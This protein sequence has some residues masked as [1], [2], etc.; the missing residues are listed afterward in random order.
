MLALVA[1]GEGAGSNRNY[2]T[3]AL[4]HAS[5]LEAAAHWLARGM[6]HFGIED[7]N[8]LQDLPRGHRARVAIA[9]A[10]WRK[11]GVSQRWIADAVDYRTA[12][13]VSQQVRRYDKQVLPI[14]PSEE[15]EWA[16]KVN[17]C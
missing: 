9:W 7:E 6:R 3:S 4:G 12:A 5:T 10:I 11:T 13:N 17:Y 2:A 14:V 15:K 1:Q 16:S 8:A